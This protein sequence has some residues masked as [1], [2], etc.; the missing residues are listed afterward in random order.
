MRKM[1]CLAKVK[2]ATLDGDG[3][4]SQAERVD[5]FLFEI[6]EKDLRLQSEASVMSLGLETFE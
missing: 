1:Q 6:R 2:L 4:E 5:G 3:G